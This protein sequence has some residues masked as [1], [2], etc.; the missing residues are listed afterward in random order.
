VVTCKTKREL[1]RNCLNCKYLRFILHHCNHVHIIFKSVL[2][3]YETFSD[4]ARLSMACSS[5]WLLDRCNNIFQENVLVP[6]FNLSALGANA[7][8]VS[9]R[10]S[11]TEDGLKIRGVST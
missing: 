4:I 5:R 10:F 9:K 6:S 7:E 3:Y 2:V 8:N 11:M 1:F